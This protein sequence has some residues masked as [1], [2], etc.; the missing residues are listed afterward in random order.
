VS[1]SLFHNMLGVA[2]KRAGLGQPGEVRQLLS[3]F[4]EVQLGSPAAFFD[5]RLEDGT[6]R[7]DG[8]FFMSAEMKTMFIRCGQF[9]VIDATCKTNR[10]GMMLVLLVGVNQIQRTVILA[11][12]LLAKENTELYTWFLDRAK[13]SVGQYIM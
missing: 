8:V 5:S 13:S 7:C 4:R 10:F 6:D 9:L 2:R 3:F 12:G 1:P 11:V